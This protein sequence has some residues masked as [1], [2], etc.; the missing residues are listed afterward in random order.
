MKKQS[1]L[2]SKAKRATVKEARAL[3][4]GDLIECYYM[5][6]EVPTH[7]LV[8]QTTYSTKEGSYNDIRTV[9]IDHLGGRSG[10]DKS[11]AW[12]NTD[13]FKRIAHGADLARSLSILAAQS[14]AIA[15]LTEA[16]DGEE[17]DDGPTE[18]RG[19]MVSKKITQPTQ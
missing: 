8:I 15:K 12:L 3:K 16:L 14:S 17:A 9:R 5:D 18:T 19:P 4:V 6:S 11:P 10:S 1:Q 2:Y 13:K 7:E